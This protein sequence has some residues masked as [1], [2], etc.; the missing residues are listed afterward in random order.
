MRPLSS[1]NT[2]QTSG[3]QELARSVQAGLVL[4]A[5]TLPSGELRIVRPAGVGVSVHRQYSTVGQFVDAPSWAAILTQQAV[6]ASDYLASR[7]DARQNY[8]TKWLSRLGFAHGIVAPLSSPVLP[9]MPGVVIALRGVGQPDFTD[10]DLHTLT[11]AAKT[12]DNDAAFSAEARLGV[13]GR[14][15]NR[16]FIANESGQFLGKSPIVS[17]LDHTLA[18]NLETFVRGRV[19]SSQE[20]TGGDRVLLADATGEAHPFTTATHANY[21]ALGTGR[22][23]IVTRVPNYT[24]WLELRGEDFAADE[25]VGR[26]LPAFRFMKDHYAEGVTLPAIAKHV[27]LSPFHFHRRFTDLLGITPKHFLYDC[28]IARAGELLL[29]SSQELE[30][31][32]KM[33]GFAHQSHFTSRFKQATGLTPTRWRKI[34]LNGNRPA[35]NPATARIG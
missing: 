31:I 9:G 22:V 24:E 35:T 15:G 14:V 23:L 32:A 5:S 16:L 33:C 8:Q 2:A 26:L 11:A 21:P 19:A 27:H 28:Q 20:S 7:N 13:K 6:R 12:L 29:E 30:D 34:R 1:S 17:G 4:V 18:D 25:E 10:T 3:L